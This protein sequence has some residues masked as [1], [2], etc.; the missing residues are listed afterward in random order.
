MVAP[1]K[2]IYVICEGKD[3]T[4]V[5]IGFSADPDKRVR[6]LQTGHASP[7]VVFYREEVEAAKVR[8]LEKIVH[9]LLSHRRQKGEWFSL[10]PANAVLEI[11]HAVMRYG[12][13]DD[14]STLVTGGTMVL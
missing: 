10:D 3:A 9:R 13:I 11:K 1:T 2:F 12:D 7:L 5:K 4:S 8:P 14:L 6:Q